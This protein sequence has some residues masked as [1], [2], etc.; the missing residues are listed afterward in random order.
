M[1]TV[2]RFAIGFASGILDSF[3]YQVSH[4]LLRCVAYTGKTM[5]GFDL[6]ADICS[7]GRRYHARIFG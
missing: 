6:G 5:D 1:K 2:V 7:I 3:N 4:K